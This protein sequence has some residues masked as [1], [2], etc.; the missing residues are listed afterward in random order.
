[1]C[2]LISIALTSIILTSCASPTKIIKFQKQPDEVF[3]NP[4]LINFFKS[5]KAP[6]IVL[7]IPNNNDKA[8]SNTSVNKDN[9]V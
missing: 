1:M 6:N 3:A 5:N 7:R 9:N 2:K 8:T 4:N